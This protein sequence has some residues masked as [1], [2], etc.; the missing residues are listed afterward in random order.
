MD[1]IALKTQAEKYRAAAQQLYE[2]GQYVNSKEAAKLA[3]VKG[4][5]YRIVLM[6]ES[7]GT[8]VNVGVGTDHLYDVAAVIKRWPSS[9]AGA[10]YTRGGD[11]AVR[12]LVLELRGG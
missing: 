5:N 7:R 9:P 1:I 12:K 11:D 3:G 6:A 2:A 4:D 8:L 10:A